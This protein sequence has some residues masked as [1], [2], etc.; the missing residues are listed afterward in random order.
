M[1]GDNPKDTMEFLLGG[2][3][4]RLDTI[5]R[6]L[7]RHDEEQKRT[8][9]EIR[10]QQKESMET[11]GGRLTSLENFRRDVRIR[12]GLIGGAVAFAVANLSPAWEFAKKIFA[13]KGTP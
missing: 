5:C 1:P 3:N 13:S 9:E 4:E 10:V 6:K 12:V 11:I 8:I 7:D 2:M